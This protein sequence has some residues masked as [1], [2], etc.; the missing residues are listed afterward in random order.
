MSAAPS[1]AALP[2]EVA[3]ACG[4]LDVDAIFIG[5]PGK[6]SEVL[7]SFEDRIQPARE[8]WLKAQ[9]EADKSTDRDVHIKAVDAQVEYD[10]LRA[11]ILLPKPWCSSRLK[12][13]PASKV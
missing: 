7:V 1:G 3:A 12:W 5:R 8:R 10:H 2:Q 9:A 6:P 11:Y 4:D 13:I